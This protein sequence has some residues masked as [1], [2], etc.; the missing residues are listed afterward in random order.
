[1]NTISQV[2]AN[3]ASTPAESGEN[4]GSSSE[5]VCNGRE[6]SYDNYNGS[7][8]LGRSRYGRTIKPKPSTNNAANS[9]Q[10]YALYILCFYILNKAFVR[11]CRFP[12]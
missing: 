8:T 3:E 4:V 1:M 12:C 2:E 9:T 11:H 6:G 5:D 10:V 7:P